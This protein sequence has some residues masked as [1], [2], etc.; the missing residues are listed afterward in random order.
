[1]ARAGR[2]RDPAARR[3]QT[4]RAGRSPVDHGT[5]ELMAQRGSLVG[6]ANAGDQRDSYALGI[7]N[8]NRR[9][10]DRQME[11]GWLFAVLRWRLYGKP[12]AAARDYRAY[13][14]RDPGEVADVDVD[15]EA[16]LRR[17]Y[18]VAEHAL[19]KQGTLVGASNSTVR[20]YFS[21]R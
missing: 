13:L 16:E 1:M 8:L 12:F 9:I 11:A 5:A 21:I 20:R 6:A 18:D 19:R 7:L 15:D 10:N 14:S 3:R 17:R 4:T 2:K